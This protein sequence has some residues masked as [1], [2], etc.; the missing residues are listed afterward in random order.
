MILNVIFSILGI[1]IY[2][3]IGVNIY[4]NFIDTKQ[5][6]QDTTVYFF[7]MYFILFIILIN[8]IIITVCHSKLLNKTGPTGPVG[9]RGDR[10]VRGINGE[11]NSNCYK[12]ELRMELI[13]FIQDTYNDLLTD[14]K[15]YTGGKIKIKNVIKE[16]KTKKIVDIKLKNNLLNDYV[17]NITYSQQYQDAISGEKT[18]EEVNTYIKSILKKWITSIYEALPDINKYSHISSH[19][20]SSL[21]QQTTEQS[22]YFADKLPWLATWLSN[23]KNSPEKTTNFFLDKYANNNNIDWK[24]NENPFEKIQKYDLYHWGR[25]RVFKPLKIYIDNNPDNSNYLPQD[26]KPPLKFLH[27]NHYKFL[28][29]NETHNTKDIDIKNKINK[30]PSNKGSIWKNN[31]V[32]KYRNEDYYPVGDLII[33]PNNNYDTTDSSYIKDPEYNETYNFSTRQSDANLDGFYDDE[34]GRIGKKKRKELGNCKQTISKTEWDYK[35]GDFRSNY[36]REKIIICPREKNLGF[37]T[38]NKET[39]L[40]TGDVADPEDYELLWD[41][42]NSY[43]KMNITIW[44]PKCPYGYESLSDVAT[45]GVDKEGKRNKPKKGTFK[46]VPRD[47]LTENKKNL[48]TILKTYDNKEIVGYSNTED[49]L[50]ASNENSYNFFRFKKDNKPLYTINEQCKTSAETK[51]KPVEDRYRELG[52]GWHGRPG[53]DPKYSIFSYLV[54][55]PEAIISSK[56]TNYKYYIVHADLY[57]SDNS[58][59]AN[60]KTSAKNLYYI[61]TLNYNNYKYDRCFSTFGDQNDLIRTRIRSEDQSYWIIEPVKNDN[62]DAIRLKSKKTGKYF[63]HNRNKNLR[64]DLVKNRVFEKQVDKD[65]E[66][67]SLIFVNV[68]SAFGTNVKT[69][70]KN[71]EPRIEEKYYLNEDENIIN[72]SKK[73]KYPKRG[74]Q[75]DN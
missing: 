44:R 36:K 15:N 16:S 66:D 32:V 41:N 30:Y 31:N 48:K 34:K 5:L 20:L 8:I 25:T 47:C 53:R 71:G 29:E 54:Q 14:D 7:I 21:T 73:Y 45:I 50:K 55:M 9:F 74:A 52:Y 51:A 26:G 39:I 43:E 65:T 46:C 62:F 4:Q 3:Y 67:D 57:D 23:N 24:N 22:L 64:R 58:K 68:K 27:T 11:C 33:G 1:I 40:V 75:T 13:N 17:D 63:Q 2:T 42:I 37:K 61:L 60:F 69:A 38:P 12:I 72:K 6:N 35:G 56:T 70:L 49:T 19:K 59:D 28:Y 18:A 10:G